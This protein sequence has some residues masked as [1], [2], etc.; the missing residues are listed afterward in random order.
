MKYQSTQSVQQKL[1]K[2]EPNVHYTRIWIAMWSWKTEL[3]FFNKVEGHCILEDKAILQNIVYSTEN[4]QNMETAGQ[5]YMK[6]NADYKNMEGFAL[7]LSMECTSSHAKQEVHCLQAK[8][9]AHCMLA[10]KPCSEQLASKT[11]SALLAGKSWNEQPAN[12]TWSALLTSK[13]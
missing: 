9:E 1:Q 7:W 5:K 10:G 13:P 3:T 6:K 8:N 11:W 2:L 4:W 12:K